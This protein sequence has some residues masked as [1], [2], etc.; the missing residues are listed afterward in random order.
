MNNTAPTTLDVLEAAREIIDDPDRWTQDAE[1]LDVERTYVEPA[2]NAITDCF[3][4]FDL[5]DL[6]DLG[7]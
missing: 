1:A 5:Y 6:F 7:A 4:L 3:D 2:L